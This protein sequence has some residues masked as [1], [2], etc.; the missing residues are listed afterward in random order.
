[1][2]A[3]SRFTESPVESDRHSWGKK[4]N[5]LLKTERECLRCGMV[6]VTRHEPGVL[7]WVEF[8]RNGEEKIV[9]NKTPP[10]PGRKSS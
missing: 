8:Y 9:C 2:N 3:R 4:E 1:M 7:P 5:F 6:K 10:C